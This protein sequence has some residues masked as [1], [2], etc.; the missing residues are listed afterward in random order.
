M[1]KKTL[2]KINDEITVAELAFKI[3]IQL[4]AYKYKVGFDVETTVIIHK[5]KENKK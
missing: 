2:D 1:D 3:N 4:I 5:E